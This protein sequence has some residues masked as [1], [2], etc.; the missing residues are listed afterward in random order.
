MPDTQAE[1][2]VPRINRDALNARTAELGAHTDDSRAQLLGI[3]RATL[4]R[5]TVGDTSPSLDAV[6]NACTALGLTRD[7]LFPSPATVRIQ[8]IDEAAAKVAANWPALTEAQKD[9][10]SRIFAPIVRAEQ[11][12]AAKPQRRAA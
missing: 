10:L 3:S 12:R 5:W 1:P 7:E 11:A 8:T 9:E 6:R 4:H 2:A